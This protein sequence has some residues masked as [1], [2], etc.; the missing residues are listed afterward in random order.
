[1]ASK[2]LNDFVKKRAVTRSDFRD[3]A[4]N[5]LDGAEK[6]LEASEKLLDGLVQE[7]KRALKI[8]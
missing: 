3:D 8:K 6:D 4:I 1:K 2:L 5:S 7:A